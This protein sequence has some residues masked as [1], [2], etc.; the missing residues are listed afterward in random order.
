MTSAD[1]QADCFAVKK[2]HPVHHWDLK[3][4]FLP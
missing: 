4:L 3:Y 2:K 1:R